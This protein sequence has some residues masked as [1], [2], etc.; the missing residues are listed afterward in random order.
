MKNVRQQVKPL[1]R[2]T[3]S[4]S[5]TKYIGNTFPSQC[6]LDNSTIL[7]LKPRYA[8]F[9]D[10]IKKEQHMIT[11]TQIRNGMTIIE[12]G[13]LFKVIEARHVTP[14]KGKAHVQV[15]LRNVK[16][17]LQAERRYNSDDKVEKAYLEK[18]EMEFLYE[19][20]GECYFMNTKTYDQIH[21]SQ[22]L[23]QNTKGYLKPN[24]KVMVEFF[25]SNPIGVELPKV[26]EFKVTDTEP[27]LKGATA[28]S[29]NKP[30]T[31]E[32]GLKVKV[33][34]F[35]EIGDTVRIDTETGEYIERG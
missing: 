2:E 10:I 33:P 34:P 32:T 31:L 26:L 8:T 24:T 27:P 3:G 20:D 21:I 1:N 5:T 17:G 22:E 35:I 28:A 19:Q 12:D 16:T 18:K 13:Q 29:S 30:A 7:R 9:T 23:L 15:K 11:A 6:P 14:G 25:E 4:E